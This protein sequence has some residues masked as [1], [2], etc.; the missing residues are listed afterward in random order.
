MVQ[1]V[2][3]AMSLV[4]GVLALGD[5]CLGDCNLGS[6]LKALGS[7]L[8]LLGSKLGVKLAPKSLKIGAR[9]PLGRVLGGSWGVLGRAC[10]QVGPS[11]PK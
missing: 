6:K 8:A 3:G 10:P 2:T 5:S 11:S 4:L 1:S 9:G 7:K